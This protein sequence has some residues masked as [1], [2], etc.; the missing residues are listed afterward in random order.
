MTIQRFYKDFNVY[1]CKTKNL[2]AYGVCVISTIQID[3][4]EICICTNYFLILAYLSH[5][6]FFVYEN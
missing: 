6:I 5:F 4:T 1:C 3:V 2:G